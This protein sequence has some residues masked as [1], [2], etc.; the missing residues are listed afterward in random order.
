MAMHI[1]YALSQVLLRFPIKIQC[2]WNTHSVSNLKHASWT[3]EHSDRRRYLQTGQVSDDSKRFMDSWSKKYFRSLPNIMILIIVLISNFP[4]NLNHANWFVT[5]LK[6]F[7][8]KVQSLMIQMIMCFLD[9]QI[10][11][12]HSQKNHLFITSIYII[13][14]TPGDLIPICSV[15]FVWAV[16]QNDPHTRTWRPSSPL[17]IY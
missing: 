15:V 17:E 14:I 4:G 2:I 11:S 6:L 13:Y 3:R 12:D 16:Q 10:H 8:I 7:L 5:F 1:F 9:L